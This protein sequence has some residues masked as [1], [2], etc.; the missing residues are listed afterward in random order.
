M[1]N[2]NYS[3]SALLR[4]GQWVSA[5]AGLRMAPAALAAGSLLA[6]G[7]L[8]SACSDVP[9]EINPVSW[10]KGV[11]GWFSDED[12]TPPPS[13]K[14]GP[15]TKTTTEAKAP[16]AQ[17]AQT[18]ASTASDQPYPAAQDV[19]E[20]PA[21]STVEQ[22]RQMMQGLS[23][24]RANAKYA[25]E[26]ARASDQSPSPQAG[27]GS[28]A[29]AKSSSGSQ[30]AASAEGGDSMMPT[31]PPPAPSPAAAAPSSAAARPSPP[32]STG[33]K[34][35]MSGIEAD[36]SN[37]PPPPPAPAK[38]GP[39]PAKSTS[40]TSAAA[41][42]PA[43]TGAVT[44]AA[45]GSAEL[46]QV[47]QSKLQESAPTVSTMPAGPMAANAPPAGS[48]A[49]PPATP[50]GPATAPSKGSKKH[51]KTKSAAPSTAE[52]AASSP[53]VYVAPEVSEGDL[54]FGQSS[55]FGAA[56][57]HDGAGAGAPGQIGVVYFGSGSAELDEGDIAKLRQVA[58]MY[59]E[60]GG[61]IRVVGYASSFTRDMDPMHHQMV[62]FNISLRRADAVARELIKLGVKPANVF[63]SARSDA[64]P[65]Y[66]ESMPAGQAGNQ[67]AEIFI[68]Y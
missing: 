34:S 3:I 14:N 37:A 44:P 9:D 23:S 18:Q 58:S 15:V 7:F 21:T 45:P 60:R 33:H 61:S 67:R 1:I 62:N 29:P 64:E 4:V 28:A 11:E 19:P 5:R 49:E 54:A 8:L 13:V 68:D 65:I 25:D 50:E 53:S 63:V 6:G 56:P 55:T 39:A 22:R 10:Y 59:Q 52:A 35:Y 36:S 41:V 40:A 2:S 31:V 43:G 24:D 57:I 17:A 47:Y 38:P 20:K 30:V 12:Q 32:P 26:S 27:A 42:A 51:A 16:A 46:N 66:F 48:V